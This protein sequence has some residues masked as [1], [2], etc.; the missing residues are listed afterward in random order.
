VFRGGYQ[1]ALFLQ[2]GGVTYAGHIAANGFN[3]KAIEVAAAEDN[4]CSSG[5]WENPEGHIGTAMQPY[6]FALHRSPNCLFKWQVIPKKQ[7]TP[8]ESSIYVVFLP[9]TVAKEKLLL[10]YRIDFGHGGVKQ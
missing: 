10:L 6:T 8:E 5:G 2:A 9:Q 1:D 3:L 7:I 4:A